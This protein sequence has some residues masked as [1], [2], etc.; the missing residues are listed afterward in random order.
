MAKVSGKGEREELGVKVRRPTKRMRYYL[1]PAAQEITKAL[2]S[3]GSN[4]K[5]RSSKG[6]SVKAESHHDTVVIANTIE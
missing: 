5:K 1:L 2:G 3:T 4:K 6:N